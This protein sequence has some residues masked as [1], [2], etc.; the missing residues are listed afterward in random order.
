MITDEL[1]LAC[2]ITAVTAL[3][4]WL[5]RRFLWA[6]QVGASLL[7]IGFGAALSNLNLVAP[8][9]PVYSTISGTLTSLA[10]VWLLLAV[11]RAQA[12]KETPIFEQI[13][14]VAPQH[15]TGHVRRPAVE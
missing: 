11:D 7:V 10:I 1:T 8:S 9:S 6:R 13:D 15:R 14:L 12:G 3:G 5:E 2:L 4:F